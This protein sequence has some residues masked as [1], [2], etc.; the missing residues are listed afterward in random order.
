MKDIEDLEN[1]S[2][3]AGT[4]LSDSTPKKKEEEFPF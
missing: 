1:R 2:L 3:D 4:H